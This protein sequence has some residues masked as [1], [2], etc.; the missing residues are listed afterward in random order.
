VPHRRRPASF[1]FDTRAVHFCEMEPWR[2]LLG[3]RSGFLILVAGWG[4]SSGLRRGQRLGAR[5]ALLYKGIAPWVWFRELQ[6]F[7][8]VPWIAL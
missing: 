5:R 4:K 8:L 1:T 3:V 7:T 2:W 6:C